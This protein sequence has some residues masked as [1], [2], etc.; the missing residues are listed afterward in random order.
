MTDRNLNIRV[1]LSAANKLSGPVSA[2]QRSAAGLASQIKATQGSIKNLGGQAKTFDRLNASINKNAAAYEAAK[3]KAKSLR[4]EFGPFNRQAEEQRKISMEARKERDRLGRALDKEK[5]KLNAVTA[6]MYRHGVS[7]R[8]SDSATAQITRRTESYNR[9]L[10]EQQRRLSAVTRMQANV[11]RAKEVRGK[12]AGAGA[13]GISVGG[14]MLYGVGRFLKPGLDFSAGMSDTQALAGLDKNA[15][16]LKAL[17]EQA[18]QLG[19]S[20]VFTTTQ[21][22]SAQKYLAQAGDSPTDIMS[23]T[24]GVLSLASA[25]GVELGFSADLMSDIRSAMGLTAKESN[26]VGDVLTAT[27]TKAT[28]DLTQLGE[29]MKYAAPNFRNIG[30]SLEDGAAMLGVMADDGVKG[31]MAGTSTQGLTRLFTEKTSK[32]ALSALG[33]SVA[34]AD[35][36]IRPVLSIMEDISKKMGRFNQ[37]SQVQLGKDLW[38]IEAQKGMAAVVKAAGSGKLRERADMNRNSDGKA[39]NIAKTKI[40]NLPGDILQMGSAFEFLRIQMAASVDEPLRALVQDIT[41]VLM[42]VGEWMKANPKLTKMLTLTVMVI[43]AAAVALGALALAAAAII[44]PFAMM[45]L[46]LFMLTGGRGLGALI[47]SAKGLTS[48]L[49]RLLPS[50]SGVGRSIKDWPGV[51]R[52]GMTALGNLRSRVALLGNSLQVGLLRGGLAVSQG[53]TFAFTQPGAALA[54]LG[55]GLRTLVTGGF[56][57]LFNVARTGLTMLGGGFSLLL[58]PVGLLAMAIVGAGLLIWKYW[59]PIK[60]FF[61]GYFTGLMEGLAPLKEAFSAAF[62]PLAPL[63]DVIGNAISKVWNWF[64]S[65]FEPVETSK[66]SLEK[67]TAAGETFGKVVGAAISALIYPIAQI[68]KGLGWIL[69]KLGVIP[70]AAE[71]AGQ[72]IAAMSPDDAK[73]LAG[74]AN[75]LLQD[76]NAITQAGK[77]TKEAEETKQEAIKKTGETAK[78]VYGSEVYGG[79]TGTKSK[80]GAAGGLNAASTENTSASDVKKLGDIVFKNRPPVAAIDGLYQEP[81]LQIQRSSLLDSLKRSVI[82]LADSVLP[83]GVKLIP[84]S[85]NR[86][87]NGIRQPVS[88]D[89]YTFEVHFHGVDMSDHRALGELVKDKLR[90]LMRE[91]DTRRRSRLSDK[92]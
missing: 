82:G 55:N 72:A 14:G 63:F 19:A 9:Q 66:E 12:L 5:Q 34:N 56:G 76:V 68:A 41:Q 10:A 16:E 39:G 31:S 85:P 15:P 90:E 43:G 73:K 29:A 49:G 53:L 38:G 61:A 70:S 18:E 88:R 58:S 51:F 87:F 26:H 2:A 6:Q 40:D 45:R 64:K 62:A 11:A 91:N 59:E 69:E 77:K 65:L 35:G 8:Q 78:Q 4:A 60:A 67:C 37:V 33:V 42:R 20:T 23:A 48:A 89:N 47:P 80:K 17:R 50:L 57:M 3:A 52:G 32:A 7:V 84:E 21:V 22:S 83:S 28:T 75:L 25:S 30:V 54:A 36:S 81:R 74:K 44:V 79:A 92:E 71:A 24:P 27:F 46:S 1:A 86:S 13:A